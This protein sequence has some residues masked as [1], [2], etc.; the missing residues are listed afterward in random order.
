MGRD[1]Q[2]GFG[3]GD[4]MAANA[5]K[6]AVAGVVIADGHFTDGQLAVA[7]A[8]KE[9]QQRVIGRGHLPLSH[10][11][12]RDF[13]RMSSAWQAALKCSSLNFSSHCRLILMQFKHL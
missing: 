9:A 13:R 8:A 1:S 5:F 2:R 10:T 7:P 3:V 11:M 4:A 12:A 6:K